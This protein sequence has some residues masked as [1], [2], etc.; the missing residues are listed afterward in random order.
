VQSIYVNKTAKNFL[1]PGP[2]EKDII[3][4][5]GARKAPLAWKRRLHKKII[6][7]IKMAMKVCAAE[8]V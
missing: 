1:L 7:I 8:A 6:M 3:L 2:V 4:Y 5:N